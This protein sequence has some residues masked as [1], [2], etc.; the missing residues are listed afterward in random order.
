MA[1]AAAEAPAT[2]RLTLAPEATAPTV[3]AAIAGADHLLIEGDNLDALKALA[4]ELGGR[5][6][7]AFIDPPYNTGRDMDYS[8]RFELS[9][10]AYATRYGLA[11]GVSHPGADR[12][13]RHA[14]WLDLMYPRL[15]QARAL[16]AEDGVLCVAIDDGEVHHLRML[17]DEVFGWHGFVAQFVWET[18]RAARG[19][20]PRTR[21]MANHEYVVCYAR[22][23]ERVVFRGLDRDAEDF[24]NPDGDPRGPWRS[25]SMKATGTRRN[26]FDLV[27]PATGRR[28]RGNW[29]FSAATL[30]R[31]VGDGLVIFPAEA[32]GTP[33][34]KKHLGSH[35]NPTKAAVTS[36]GWHSTEAATKALMALFDGEKVFDF[37]K[38]MPLIRFFCD[39]LLRPG[40]LAL[41]FFAGSGTTA[42]AV[43]AQ[44]AEDGGGRRVILVQRPEP[45]PAQ[46]TAAKAGFR[47]VADVL[48]ARL[49]LAGAELGAP[50]LTRLLLV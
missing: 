31:M 43:W 10:S 13:R 36:L 30:S 8:D 16:L 49:R 33:R 48:H 18:K 50:P 11:R 47:T 5:V 35:R 25:E 1:K 22:D 17:C 7:L 38:P 9:L 29:A 14:A 40:D 45:C 26:V 41:D 32:D 12:G 37:P 42:H 23:R 44:N 4:P 2:T 20:P 21:L 6:R 19:V 34:Q 39:Q 27:D 28:F 3:A 46:G 15:L 24:A